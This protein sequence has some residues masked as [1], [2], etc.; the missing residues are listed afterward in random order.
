MTLGR[1]GIIGRWKPLHHGGSLLLDHACR[2][3]DEV[4]IGIG[5]SNKYNV[6]NPFTPEETKGMIDA[7]LSRRHSNY[8]TIFIPDYGHL[9]GHSDGKSWKEHVISSF[10]TLDHFITGNAYVAT[11]LQDNYDII[12]PWTLIPPDEQIP[13][14]ATEV[15]IAMAKG[16]TW[17]EFVPDETAAYIENHNLAARFRREFGL[18]TLI[19]LTGTAYKRDESKNEEQH[20]TYET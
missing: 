6:R 8:R 10:G 1:V 11:L 13:I 19:N 20:H 17:K 14:R 4:I 18:E 16:D 15:R 2:L 9:P 5:S 3:A 12:P 7:Y